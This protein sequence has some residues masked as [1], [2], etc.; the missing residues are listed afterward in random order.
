MFNLPALPA[1]V[2]GNLTVDGNSGKWRESYFGG[3][4]AFDKQQMEEYAKEAILQYIK[5]N[6]KE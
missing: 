6:T 1:P 5:D 2:F 3:E 4:P